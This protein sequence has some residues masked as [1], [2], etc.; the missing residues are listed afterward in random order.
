VWECDGDDSIVVVSVYGCCPHP[1]HALVLV[2]SVLSLSFLFSTLLLPA[3]FSSFPPSTSFS[4]ILA[5]TSSRSFDQVS[6]SY[7]AA[8]V[9][10]AERGGTEWCRALSVGMVM[11]VRWWY[12]VAGRGRWRSRGA[13]TREMTTWSSSSRVAP[14]AAAQLRGGGRGGGVGCIVGLPRLCVFSPFVFVLPPLS[15]F[16]PLSPLLS[17]PSPLPSL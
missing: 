17:P 8:E 10:V 15:L 4:F 3:L 13:V 6:W 16:S 9:V 12:A 5:G 2:V 11:G 7:K 1:A 14:P